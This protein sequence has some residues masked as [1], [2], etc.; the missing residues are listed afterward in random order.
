MTI[1]EDESDFEEIDHIADS[2]NVAKSEQE[3]NET[4]DSVES[5]E[6]RNDF[7]QPHYVYIG[8]DRLSKWRKS[9]PV[10]NI[11]SRVHNITPSDS[12]K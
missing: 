6:S 1:R 2:E 11:R 8:K 7:N 9:H 3:A 10:P 4:E 5:T 12:K